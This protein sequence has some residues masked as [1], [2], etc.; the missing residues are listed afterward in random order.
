MTVLVD[1]LGLY[2]DP[3][4]G[5]SVLLLG[6]AN[7]VTRV[8]PVFIGP[9]EAQAIAIG[10][11]GLTLPRPGTHDLM[12]D[13]VKIMGGRLDRVVV[14]ALEEG[15]FLAELQIDTPEGVLTMSSR[16]SDGVALAV[17]LGAQVYIEPSVLDEAGVEVQHELD[18]PFEEEEIEAIVAEFEDFLATVK[19]SDFVVDPL[20]SD[21][22]AMTLPE[23]SGEGDAT[24]PGD[25]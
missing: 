15:T 22:E 12:A 1:I 2:L 23:D 4:S 7:E 8:L 6:E 20:T 17:R 11:Q 14:T 16:P 18:Q 13:L 21:E 19:P 25:D 5:S 9:A 3:G 10:L 24:P